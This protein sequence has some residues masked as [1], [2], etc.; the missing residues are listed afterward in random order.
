MAQAL[1]LDEN[2]VFLFLSS[3]VPFFSSTHIDKTYYITIRLSQPPPREKEDR[4]PFQGQA[5]EAHVLPAF[6]RQKQICQPGAI[7]R[8]HLGS[9]PQGPSNAMSFFRN[10]RWNISM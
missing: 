2:R 1:F 8:V 3:R 5:D 9:E 6:S 4:G 7:A 10:Y